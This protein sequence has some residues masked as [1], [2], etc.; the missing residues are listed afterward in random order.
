MNLVAAGT[1]AL[2]ESRGREAECLFIAIS[3]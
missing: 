1:H 3:P 2:G